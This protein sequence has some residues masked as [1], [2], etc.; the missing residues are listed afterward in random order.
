MI[1]GLILYKVR[2]Y[3]QGDELSK[4]VLEKY[5]QERQSDGE[6]KRGAR[7]R[8]TQVTRVRTRH[9]ARLLSAI[10]DFGWDRGCPNGRWICHSCL[11][12]V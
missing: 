12:R 8:K 6:S 4:N 1:K 3:V 5:N 2:S 7:R 11:S 9:V 10:T